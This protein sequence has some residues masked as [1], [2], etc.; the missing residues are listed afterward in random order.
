MY[1]G[2]DPIC[3]PNPPCLYGLR[4]ILEWPR[5]HI[6]TDNLDLT[7]NLPVGVIGHADPTRFGDGLKAG[8]YIHAI[9]EDVV[10]IKNDVT[11]VNANTKFYPLILRHNDIGMSRQNVEHYMR[12]RDQMKDGADGQKRLRLVNGED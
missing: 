12:F 5:S 3:Q 8:R 10:F 7:P 1:R 2:R 11:D 6:I 9:T 4:N